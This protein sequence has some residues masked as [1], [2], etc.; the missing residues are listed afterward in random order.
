MGKSKNTSVY[1]IENF[2]YRWKIKH[3]ILPFTNHLTFIEQNVKRLRQKPISMDIQVFWSCFLLFFCVFLV[4]IVSSPH[5]R[6][7]NDFA[8]SFEQ[9]IDEFHDK[10]SLDGWK[11]LYDECSQIVEDSH[12]LVLAVLSNQ[13]TNSFNL[14]TN[15]NQIKGHLR[16]GELDVIKPFIDFFAWVIIGAS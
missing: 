10:K 6:I 2:S 13:A 8:H 12:F 11:I 1:W 15:R 3:F 5:F 4:C 7:K 9:H 14:F 16:L